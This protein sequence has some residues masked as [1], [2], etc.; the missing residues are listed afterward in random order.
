MGCAVSEWTVTLTLTQPGAA[1]V[2]VDFPLPDELTA[3][4]FI[5]LCRTV[6]QVVAAH[7]KPLDNATAPEAV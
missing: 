3:R 1:D 6:P 7:A 4:R 2:Q 5:D